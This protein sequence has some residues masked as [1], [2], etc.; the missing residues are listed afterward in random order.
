MRESMNHNTYLHSSDA[1]TVNI[2]RFP[3]SFGQTVK[4][5][6]GMSQ[7]FFFFMVLKV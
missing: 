2:Q 6:V 1:I 5:L 3:N 4:I 7:R